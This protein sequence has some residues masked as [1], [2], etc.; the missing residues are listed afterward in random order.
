MQYPQICPR[1]ELPVGMAARFST[2]RPPSPAAKFCRPLGVECFDALTKV[3]RLPEPAIAMALKFNRR[4]EGRVFCVVKQLLGS[5]LRER[6][7]GATLF[8]QFIGRSFEIAIRHP[9]G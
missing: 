5:A 6:R 2:A 3:V 9:F 1:R 8:H 4:R 7:E